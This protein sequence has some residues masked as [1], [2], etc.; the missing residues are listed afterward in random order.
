MA[1]AHLLS[2]RLTDGTQSAY[3]L[4]G[5]EIR[6]KF[7]STSESM[8]QDSDRSHV[9]WFAAEPQTAATYFFAYTCRRA[10]QSSYMPDTFCYIIGHRLPYETVSIDM[11]EAKGVENEANKLARGFARLLKDF[12]M[13]V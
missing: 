5:A 9:E 8:P 13:Q 12:R 7:N 3:S 4:S 6:R 1:N 2:E 10:M 11:S